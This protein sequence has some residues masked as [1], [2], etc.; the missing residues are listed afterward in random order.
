MDL[1]VDAR[2]D[3][4]N[5]KLDFKIEKMEIEQI[6]ELRDKDLPIRGQINVDID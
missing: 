2:G 5:A 1:R 6:P 4:Y 3:L